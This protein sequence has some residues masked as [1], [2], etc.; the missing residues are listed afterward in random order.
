MKRKNPC[1]LLLFVVVVVASV[2][3][4]GRKS[5]D[6]AKTEEPVVFGPQFSAKKGLL[7]PTN[8]RDS[9]GLRIVEVEEQKVPATFEVQLRIYQV[10]TPFSLASGMVSPEKAKLLKSGQVVEVRD[11]DGKTAS[12][13]VASLNDQLQKA[14]G[15]VELLVEIPQAPEEFTAGTFV[16]ASVKLDSSESVVTIPRSALLQC[17]DGHSVYTVSGE[18]L[19]RTPIKIGNANADLVEVKDGLY[20]GD[21]VVLQPVMSLWM[22]E[23][24]AVKGGQACCVEPAK[25]K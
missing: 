25:G 2:A 20:A 10:G 3:G 5:D 24:A 23:L 7:V 18:H 16:R 21:K 1:S 4:C 22:T 8:T 11:R 15:G 14:T 13:K 17:S 9:L 12:A 6:S 19:V